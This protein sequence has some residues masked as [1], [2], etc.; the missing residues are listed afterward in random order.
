MNNNQAKIKASTQDHLD[1]EEIQEGLVILKNGACALVLK[2]TAINFG[3]LSEKEQEATIF[4]YAGFL[5]SLTFPTQIIIHSR[6]KDISAYLSLIDQQVG[7][8]SNQKLKELGQKYRRFIE[9]IV[10]KNK[11]LDKS[12]YIAIPYSIAQLKKN[13]LNELLE[14]AKTFL[15]PV[16]DHLIG[17]F[18]RLGLKAVQLTSQELVELFHELYNPEAEGQKLGSPQSYNYTLVQ[19]FKKPIEKTPAISRSLLTQK[20]KKDNSSHIPHPMNLLIPKPEVKENIKPAEGSQLQ[21]QINTI[22]KKVGP[23]RP[24]K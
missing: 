23:I 1:I 10:K 13:K 20:E 9:T 21:K 16:R 22:V 8:Q 14:K 18:Q 17:Q 4:A 5:N 11:V 15:Y 12:F 19:A 7:Q 6:Q 24:G 2:T 3:L